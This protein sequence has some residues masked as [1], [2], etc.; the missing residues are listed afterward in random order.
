VAGWRTPLLLYTQWLRSLAAAAA[1]HAYIPDYL[2]I[3]ILTVTMSFSSGPSTPV[4]RPMRFTNG[5]EWPLQMNPPESAGPS[6]GS[7][8]SGK[9]TRSK[10]K[11]KSSFDDTGAL[12]I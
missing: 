10:D 3:P 8:K 11:G 9:L 1:H 12:G 7:A 4:L 5:A 6:G 2:T